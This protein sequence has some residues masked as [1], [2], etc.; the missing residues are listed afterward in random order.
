MSDMIHIARSGIIAARTA[1]AVTSENVA[2][3][4]TEGYR[5]RDVASV[6]NAGGQTTPTTQP[7]GGQRVSVSEVRRAFDQLVAQRLWTATS[8]Q[9]ASAAHR[10]VA[11]SL[12][13][14]FTPGENGLD[15]TMRDFFDSLSRLAASPADRTTRASALHGAQ[16]LATEIVATA[17]GAAQLRA[18][19]VA[20]AQMTTAEAQ[21]I[22]QDL[23]VL[24]ERL[25][26][27]GQSETIGHHPL[28]DQ[29]DAL[30]QRAAQLLPASVE[31]GADG[32]AT[33]RLGS[34]AGPVLLDGTGPTRLHVSAEDQLTLH[35]TAPDGS[36]RDTR[37]LT[38]GRLGGLAM[39]LGALDMAAQE[40]DK[41]ARDMVAGLNQLHRQ[42][43]DVLGQPGGDLFTMDGWQAKPAAANAGKV[44]VQV[45]MA[46]PQPL[47]GPLELVYDAGGPGW[48]ARDAG[49][50]VL[51]T[52]HDRLVLPGV[53]V[54]LAGAPRNGDR[55]VL[56]QVTGR[57]IDLRLAI[58]DADE[59]AAAAD[60]LVAPALG[61]AGAASLQLSRDAGEPSPDALDVVIADATVGLVELRN[62]SDDSLVATGTLAGDG[63]VTL[64]GLNLQLQG[65]G[66]TGDR[67][68]LRPTAAGSGN[69]ATAQAMADLRSA[70]GD[71]GYGVLDSLSNFQADLGTR[72]AAVQRADDTAQARLDSAAAEDAALGAVNLDAEAARMVELQQAYQASAQA[73]SI[74]RSLFDTLLRMI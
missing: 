44:Q 22:L 50:T 62:P 65:V 39:G 2:N 15:G 51:A 20:Q 47:N 23:H 33:L 11:D 41:L 53:T 8:A 13:T 16:T 25:A 37:M 38:G 46:R 52:G 40:F 14:R 71:G 29:R 48:T 66:Q 73:M 55:I 30:L 45:D 67:F 3:V 68:T 9:S 17:Q 7:T 57:A 36:R 28:A 69:G 5:R 64:A 49:G 61:N 10:Q 24:N 35:M 42:G 63:R 34:E 1:L 6:S 26:H 56:E 31:L 72:A 70:R 12:E 32:R 21:G 60:V 74:A 54:D 58:G 27:L 43:T 4:G 18:D 59:L 19:T